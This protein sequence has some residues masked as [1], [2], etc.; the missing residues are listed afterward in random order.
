MLHDS[1]NTFSEQQ[2]VTANAASTDIMDCGYA[3]TVG[4]GAGK[5]LYLVVE[6]DEAFNNLTSVAFAFQ[7]DDNSSFSSP[8]AVDTRTIALASLAAA[9]I[10]NLYTFA[11]PPTGLERYLRMYYTVTGTTPTTGKVTAY[12]STVAEARPIVA[13][14]VS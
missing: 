11:L 6:L 14:P 9:N 1:F 7:T 4:I 10:G 12:L 13:G 2:A 8:T 5:Q 3:T